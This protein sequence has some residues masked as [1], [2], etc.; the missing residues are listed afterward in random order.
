M[1]LNIVPARAGIQWVKLG[2]QTFL[3]QPL[4]LSGL[5]FMY[6]MALLLLNLVP[7]IGLVVSLAVV[8]AATLGFM[9]ASR[10]VN[11]GRFP[12]PTVLLTA[13][14]A[15]QQRFRAML[16]LGSVFAATLLAVN[17][18]VNVMVPMPPVPEKADARVVLA[19]PE[20]Q[21]RFLLSNLLAL[22]VYLAFWHAPALVHWHGIS[23]VKSIFFSTVAVLRNFGALVVYG[24]GWFG[25]SLAGVL[26]LSVTQAISV[27]LA[28]ALVLPWF[29]ITGTMFFASIYFTFRDSFVADEPP[30]PETNDE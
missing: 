17:L 28:T 5:F 19:M 1:K 11:E 3:R 6:L 13:F 29:L 16:V 9:A 15:G 10:Q 14:R 2:V 21:T 12:L 7:V 25:V 18:L 26:L 27:F 23:P 4:A 30:L 20:F 8:P 24:L 22:P